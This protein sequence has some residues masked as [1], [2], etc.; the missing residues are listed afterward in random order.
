M[1]SITHK[2]LGD[3]VWAKQDWL[4]LEYSTL[5]FH[6]IFVEGR[7]QVNQSWSSHKKVDTDIGV[8][9]FSFSEPLLMVYIIQHQTFDFLLLS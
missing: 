6:K 4:E 8:S 3:D 7:K 2:L 1:K 5:T 9:V